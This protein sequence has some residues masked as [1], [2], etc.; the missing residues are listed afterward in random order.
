MVAF[1]LSIRDIIIGLVVAILATLFAEH[2]STWHKSKIITI[3]KRSDEFIEHSKKYYLPLAHLVAAIET[4]TAPHYN[5]VRPKILFFKL[6][7]YLTFYK[8]FFD[9]GIGFTFP[10]YTQ[11]CKVA[12]CCDTFNFAISYWIF[13]DDS[14]AMERVIK[15]YNNNPDKLS[16]IERIDTLP[17]YKTFESICKN[18]EIMEMLYKYSDTLCNSITKGVTDEYG[19]WYKFELLKRLNE[20]NINK[21]AE[22]EIETIKKLH[23]N[24]HGND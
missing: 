6:A 21:D 22:R 17:E 24:I 18:K 9:V 8:R 20:R 11:E 5:K 7:K 13:N 15:Y 4:E 12:K 2:I 10:K 23:Q 16:F 14:E 19:I 3:Q 1:E